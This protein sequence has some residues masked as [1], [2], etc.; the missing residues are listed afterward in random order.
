MIDDDFE[1]IFELTLFS[2]NIKME[3]CGDLSFL[4]F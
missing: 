1:I 3:M 4:S 2:S